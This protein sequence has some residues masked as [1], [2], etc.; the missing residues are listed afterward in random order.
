MAA[1]RPHSFAQEAIRRSHISPM[2]QHGVDQPT[3]VIDRSKQVPPAPADSY[4]G[5]IHLPGA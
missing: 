2:G 5:L 4:I 3:V 1:H